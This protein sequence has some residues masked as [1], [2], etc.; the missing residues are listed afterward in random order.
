MHEIPFLLSTRHPNYPENQNNFP[1][2]IIEGLLHNRIIISSLHYKQLTG[3][4]YLECPID[5]EGFV[6]FVRETLHR[7]DIS[8]FA[9]QSKIVREQFSTEVWNHTITKIESNEQ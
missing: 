6:C 1:S 7:T 5:I 3:I 8:D 9:N 4:N 2:K